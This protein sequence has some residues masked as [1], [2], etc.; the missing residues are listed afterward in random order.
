MMCR[1]VC[2]SASRKRYV[3]GC[4]VTP[5]SSTALLNV[6]YVRLLTLRS[7]AAAPV[8]MQ[9]RTAVKHAVA[10][11]FTRFM[12][13]L[14]ARD[15]GIGGARAGRLCRV[16]E[17]AGRGPFEPGHIEPPGRRRGH[18]GAAR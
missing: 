5:G 14:L 6:R 16:R 4:R 10:T 3:P 18:S 7:C 17:S 11:K 8:V 12:D 2:E 15:Y 13:S 1:L 9:P